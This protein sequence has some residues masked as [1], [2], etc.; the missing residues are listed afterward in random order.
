MEHNKKGDRKNSLTE[1]MPSVLTN[2]GN[3]KNSETVVN[4][5]N[6]FFLTI[7]KNLNLHQVKREDMML[8][9]FNRCIPYKVS[10]H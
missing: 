3:V 2:S 4:A 7:T 6:N 10:R 8:F 1:Q 9:L 5:F